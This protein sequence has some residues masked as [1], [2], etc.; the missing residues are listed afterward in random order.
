MPAP[1]LRFGAMGAEVI[2][3]TVV[4]RFTVRD[5]PRCSAVASPTAPSRRAVICKRRERCREIC[6]SRTESTVRQASKRG[7]NEVETSPETRRRTV[8][9]TLML[10][11][12][13]AETE[14][15]ADGGGIEITV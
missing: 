2:A 7:E 5:C 12:Y 8:S 4:K 15:Q 6:V 9:A 14:K 10:L 1:N 11:K 13:V 3:R